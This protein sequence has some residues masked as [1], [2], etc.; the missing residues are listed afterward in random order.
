MVLKVLACKVLMR[1]ISLLIPQ[2]PHCIDVTWI[3][4][5]LHNTPKTLQRAL[6]AEID[7]ID[8]GKDI[9][10]V[11][12]QTNGVPIDAILLGY[13]LCGNAIEG[14]HSERYPIVVPRAHDC[15]SLLLGSKERYA[16]L[17]E[18]MGGHAYWYSPGWIENATMPSERQQCFMRKK[19]TAQ[20][21]E[22]GAQYLLDMEKSWYDAYEYAAYIEWDG[23]VQHGFMDFAQDAAKYLNWTYR[24]IHGEDTLLRDMLSGNWDEERFLIVPPGKTVAPSFDSRILTMADLQEA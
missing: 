8:S 4:Q 12:E 11:D 22:D 24:H 1:E 21:G 16:E 6:Q 2:N 15:V 9:R 23:I 3:R 10:S 7:A 5:G 19:Y 20:Y 18:Q 17:F 14:L 13:G